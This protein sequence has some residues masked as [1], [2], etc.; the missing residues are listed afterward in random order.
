[1]GTR[2]ILQVLKMFPVFLLK[3]FFPVPVPIP[4]QASVN[5]PL[6]TDPPPRTV[7]SGRYASYWN[8]FLLIVK[9]HDN[10][11]SYLGKSNLVTTI[12]LP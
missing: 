1:M 9:V 10:N 12:D 4:D 11:S 3:K 8:T 7:K 5:T 2:P 6:D